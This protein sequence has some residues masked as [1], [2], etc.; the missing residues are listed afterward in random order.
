M[1]NANDVL[2]TV[3]EVDDSTNSTVWD[4]NGMTLTEFGN[5]FMTR[6]FDFY[7]GTQTGFGCTYEIKTETTENDKEMRFSVAIKYED[8]IGDGTIYYQFLKLS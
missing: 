3:V 7:N 4:S 8:G 1:P 6:Q 2:V 5:E